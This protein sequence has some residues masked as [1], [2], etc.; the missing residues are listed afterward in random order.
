MDGVW[1]LLVY[2]FD[3]H[4]NTRGDNNRFDTYSWIIPLASG[5]IEVTSAPD[6]ATLDQTGEISISWPTDSLGDQWYVGAVSH[7]GKGILREATFVS[8]ENRAVAQPR[9]IDYP[10]SEEFPGL[11]SGNEAFEITFG[12]TGVYTA[13]GHGFGSATQHS[14]YIALGEWEVY[15]FELL[16]QVYFQA[17][18]TDWSN[19]VS[20]DIDMVRVP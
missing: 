4:D 17:K 18:M 7:T 11:E 10:F 16:N 5:D 20:S 1:S 2:G 9:V 3:I 15:E 6:S 19:S 13:A 8:F 14:G 12:Y